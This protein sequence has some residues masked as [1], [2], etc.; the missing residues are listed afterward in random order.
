MPSPYRPIAAPIFSRGTMRY[1]I[2]NETTGRIPP[3][4]ACRMRKITRLLRSQAS[5][6]SADPHHHTEH[7]GV[8]RDDPL[9]VVGGHSELVLQGG[10]GDVD[11]AGVEDGHE[12]PD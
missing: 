12:H 10:N 4:I 3:G 6:H 9:H 7:Q 1:T 5:P 8:S 11:D 2:G